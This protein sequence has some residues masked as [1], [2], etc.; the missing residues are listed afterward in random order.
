MNFRNKSSKSVLALA[1]A[2]VA[3]GLLASCGAAGTGAESAAPSVAA[4][5]T[6]AAAAQTPSQVL[7]STAWETT[8][9][10]DAAGKDVPLDDENVSNFVGFAYFK[11]AGD[12]VMFTLDDAPKMQGEWNVTPDGK[13]RHIVAKDESGK[14]LFSRDSD[15][16]ELTADVFTY[17]VFPNPDDK[18][19]YFDII[20]TPTTHTQPGK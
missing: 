5:T 6:A 9:A 13:T 18:S 15:I 17:R 8:G 20:H 19:V 14:E 4:E 12:F 10:L 7:A 2:F 1:S 16:V 3:V 11:E